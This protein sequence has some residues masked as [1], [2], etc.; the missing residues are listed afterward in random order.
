MSASANH[1]A[2]FAPS[3]TGRLHVG[4]ARTFLAV[5]LAARSKGGRVI[6]RIED[7]DASRTRPGM[8]RAA[9]DDLHWLGLD[10][11]EGPDIGGPHA[12]YVQSQRTR[13]YLDALESLKNAEAVY[14]C[15]CTRA[16]LANM[17]SAP[18]TDD[19]HPAVACPC[20]RRESGDA[21]TLLAAPRPFAWRIR[22]PD[23]AVCWTDGILGEM[24][25][26]PARDG[27]DFVVARST[28][29]I[30]YQLAVVA[31]DAAMGITQVIRGD[32]LVP[33]TPRQILLYRTLGLTQ[34]DFAHI[35]LVVDP[36]GQR[37]A[38]RDESL[39][40]STLREAGIEPPQLIGLLGESLG[41]NANPP[42]ASPRDLITAFTLDRVPCEVWSLPAWLVN[43][44]KNIAR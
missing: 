40:L 43:A 4:H 33:S 24:S 30:A 44:G 11:D 22:C 16:D 2:R 7:L 18:H 1:V 20:R 38:K 27:G 37:L 10:W 19:E 26:N 17:A 14:P 42:P 29:E 39:K 35:P 6:L 23:A 5:W 12:P 15:T 25:S 13:I 41:I 32:D 36:T 8:D 31:D 28:G 34:P 3:P 21:K 9:I